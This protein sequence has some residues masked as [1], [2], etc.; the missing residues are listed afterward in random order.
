LRHARRSLQRRFSPI[1]EPELDADLEQQRG[2]DDDQQ[3]RNAGNQR[4]YRNEPDVQAPVPADDRSRRTTL[5]NPTSDQN[6]QRNCRDEIAE[7]QQGNDKRRQQSLGVGAR[8]HCPSDQR[9]CG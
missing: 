3:G 7:K 2:K 1:R 8:Q 5:C 6:E 4:E 9:H